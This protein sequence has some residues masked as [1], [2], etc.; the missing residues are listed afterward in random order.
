MRVEFTDGGIRLTDGHFEWNYNPQTKQYSKKPVPWDSRGRRALNEFFYNY[1][2]IADLVK[3]AGF[4]GSPGKDS[5][6]I[7][8]TY[9]L[10]GGVAAEEIKT[11]WIDSR[12][13][14]LR[15]ISHPAAIVEPPTAGPVRLT[16]TIDF[17]NVALNPS[18]EPSLF[19]PPAD[20]PQLSGAIRRGIAHAL[21][22]WLPRCPTCRRDMP[23]LES[24]PHHMRATPRARDPAQ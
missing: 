16:R 23:H 24:S 19:T 9:E 3:S 14:V 12:Y 4:I 15:E 5:F 2:G 7:E 18:L 13:V 22:C 10:P 11:Y 21:T 17:Q 20:Q 1:E 6:V 8:A